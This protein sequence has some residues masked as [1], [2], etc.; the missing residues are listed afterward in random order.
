MSAADID[1][2]V[3]TALSL[4]QL[5]EASRMSGASLAAGA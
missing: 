5:S 4:K 3:S 1:G 2:S